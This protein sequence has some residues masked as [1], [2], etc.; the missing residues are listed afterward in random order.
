MDKIGLTIRLYFLDVIGV[1]VLP[2]FLASIIILL[3]PMV[4]AVNSYDKKLVS[5]K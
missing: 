2:E 5:Y 3:D 4:N 1:H